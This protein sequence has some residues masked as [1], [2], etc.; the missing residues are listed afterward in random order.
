LRASG[1]PEALRIERMSIQWPRIMISMSEAS[2][3]KKTSPATQK[4]TPP[5]GSLS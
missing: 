3:Q 4:V 2:P 1:A 5:P